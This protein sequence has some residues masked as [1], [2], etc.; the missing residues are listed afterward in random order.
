MMAMAGTLLRAPDRVRIHIRW[1]IRRDLSDVMR[2]E[3]DSFEYSW[4]EEDFLRCLRQRNCIGDR[5]SVV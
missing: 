1:M 5:K 3:L 4:N 2:T